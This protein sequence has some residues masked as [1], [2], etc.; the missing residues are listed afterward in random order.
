MLQR[1]LY[2]LI[3][4]FLIRAVYDEIITKKIQQKQTDGKQFVFIKLLSEVRKQT[5][6]VTN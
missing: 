3:I 4:I 5:N 6:F 2:R 1:V